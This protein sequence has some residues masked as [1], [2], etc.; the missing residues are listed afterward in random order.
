MDINERLSKVKEREKRIAESMSRIKH[1]VAVLSGKGGVGKTTVSVNLA[2]GLIEEGFRVGLLDLDL[3]GPNVARMLGVVDQP[4][5]ENGKIVPP[6]YMNN[7]KVISM[8][9]LIDESQPLI[10]RGPLKHSA[11]QQFLGD[12]DW[13]ELDFLIFDLPPGTG[14]EAL[15]LFQTVQMDGVVVVTTPQRVA[16]DDVSR[17]INF[18]LEMNQR[19][20]GLVI[21]MSYLICPECKAKIEPFGKNIAKNFAELVGV[22]VLGEIPMDP[23][24]ASFADSGKPVVS[25][26]RGSEGEKS[27]RK[28]IGEMLEKL[29]KN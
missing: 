4:L 17:A 9:M 3:H 5:S 22:D 24:I 8:A 6:T 25:F 12:V 15:S 20:L 27:F 13:G 28:I 16:I 7:L 1:K 10:W 2:V 26:L 21:N 23:M 19:V 29:A 14:D 18:V 11:I